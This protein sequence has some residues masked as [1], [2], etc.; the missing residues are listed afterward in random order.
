MASADTQ[1]FQGKG[2]GPSRL[3]WLIVIGQLS[4]GR[5][6]LLWLPVRFVLIAAPGFALYR[7]VKRSMRSRV[8]ATAYPARTVA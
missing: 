3:C 5:T 2:G 7:F 4:P 6:R 1:G 8:K